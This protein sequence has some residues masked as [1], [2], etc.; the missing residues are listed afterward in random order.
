MTPRKFAAGVCLAAGI[1]AAGFMANQ[2]PVQLASSESVRQT[3]SYVCPMHPNYKSDL[4]GD[5]PSCGMRLV[6]AEAGPI[7][8]T[9]VVRVNAAT[10]QLI[11]IET[12]EVRRESVSHRMR[13]AGRIAVDE[14]RLYRLLAAADGWV[15][16][17]G[18]NTTGA[19]VRKDQLL[20]SY[21][22]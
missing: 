9:G 3:L 12:A 13:T 5:C 1:F 19:F 18:Q 4:P 8:A 20:V 21:Y 17:L 10:Q 11:G 2:R 7:G 16:E 6:R 15:R 22:V 14:A